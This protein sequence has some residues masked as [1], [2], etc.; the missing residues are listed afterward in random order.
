MFPALTLS[1]MFFLVPGTLRAAFSLLWSGGVAGIVEGLC[2]ALC[3]LGAL[4]ACTYGGARLLLEMDFERYPEEI[5]PRSALLRT[6]YPSGRWVPDAQRRQYG[7]LLSAVHGRRRALAMQAEWYAAAMALVTSVDARPS[8]CALQYGVAAAVAYA[9]ALVYGV[10]RPCRAPASNVLNCASLCANGSMAAVLALG[11]VGSLSG[12]AA[13]SITAYLSLVVMVLSLLITLETMF[14]L[15]FER[16][17]SGVG[18][19]A[20]EIVACTVSALAEGYSSGHTRQRSTPPSARQHLQH[21]RPA[22]SQGS[23]TRAA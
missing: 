17:V 22:Q 9:S 13:A 14:Q 1:L 18:S 10:L 19:G 7:P 6:L 2:A 3:V 20:A 8:H 5:L 15:Y 4:A 11:A 12:N 23:A 21:H 16:S